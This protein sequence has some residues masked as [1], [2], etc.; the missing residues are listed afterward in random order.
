MIARRGVVAVVG[1]F[2]ASFHICCRDLSSRS[3]A[4]LVYGLCC[5][6]VGGRRLRWLVCKLCSREGPLRQEEARVWSSA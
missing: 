3:R 1:A 5:G 6:S 2:A 4:W